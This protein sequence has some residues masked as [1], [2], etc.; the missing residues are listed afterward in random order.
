MHVLLQAT[1]HGQGIV[2][3][4]WAAGFLCLRGSRR[5]DAN[6]Q[7]RKVDTNQEVRKVATNQEVS[8]V[9]K[10]TGIGGGCTR[11][12]TERE[13]LK[14]VLTP[15]RC[16]S[17][18][19]RGGAELGEGGRQVLGAL[20]ELHGGGLVADGRH[21]GLGSGHHLG[22]RLCARERKTHWMNW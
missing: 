12:L 11:P 18:L 14:A 10:K 7:V 4:Q 20:A 13:W 2:N 15:C 9:D 21:G 8:K 5:A 3:L 19:L 6:Q 16:Y 22:S 1:H 17:Y